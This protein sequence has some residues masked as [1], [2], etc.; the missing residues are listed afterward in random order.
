MSRFERRK[1]VLGFALSLF[2]GALMIVAGAPKLLGLAPPDHVARM[3]LTESIRLVGAGE[4]VTGFL[5][6]IP[7]TLSLG[8]LLTSS[9]W[10]GAI[11]AHMSHGQSYLLQSALLVFSW[12]GAYLR[13][14]AVLGSF[15]GRQERIETINRRSTH[16]DNLGQRTIRAVGLDHGRLLGD[17]P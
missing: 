1:R 12:V 2:I 14:P 10:G 6:L 11:C 7:R 13:N 16:E 8:I 4:I 5:L 17:R 3:G 15:W 9:F